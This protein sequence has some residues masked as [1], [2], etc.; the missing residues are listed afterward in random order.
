MKVLTG[1]KFAAA[2]MKTEDEGILKSNNTKT[3]V[4]T[5]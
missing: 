4:K 5:A 2:K 3:M 1:T